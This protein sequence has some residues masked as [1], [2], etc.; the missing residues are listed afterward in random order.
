MA[1]LSYLL[2]I[3]GV[4]IN[5]FESA[6]LKAAGEAIKMEEIRYCS[7]NNEEDNFIEV[8]KRAIE[9]YNSYLKQLGC[10]TTY[11]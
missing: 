10:R 6:L 7:K 1:N 3:P 9:I 11:R 2:G 8:M 5:L 4:T